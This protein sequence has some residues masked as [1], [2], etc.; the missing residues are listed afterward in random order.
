VW[1]QAC[2]GKLVVSGAD[3][4]EL[5]EIPSL[6]DQTVSASCSQLAGQWNC[7]QLT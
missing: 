3:G 6:A 5:G 4:N 2:K 1:K 7:V